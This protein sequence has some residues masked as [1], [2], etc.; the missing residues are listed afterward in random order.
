[1]KNLMPYVRRS[2]NSVTGAK[3][4]SSLNA[5][6]RPYG[7]K[8]YNPMGATGIGR[9]GA[10]YRVRSNGHNSAQP[11][12]P[13]VSVS[14][15]PWLTSTTLAMSHVRSRGNLNFGAASPIAAASANAN[16]IECVAPR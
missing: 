10:K 15:S 4:I 14:R 3:R 16:A 5:T 12:P 9:N 1:M 7:E 8:K 13:S 6:K 2:A 11:S